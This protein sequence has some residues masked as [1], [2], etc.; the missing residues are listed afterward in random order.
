MVPKRE[1]KDTHHGA[2]FMPQWGCPYSMDS[3]KVVS[4]CGTCKLNQKHSHI[5][6]YGWDEMWCYVTGNIPFPGV[7]STIVDAM[8]Q[9][10]IVADKHFCDFIEDNIYKR[11]YVIGT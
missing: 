11:D 6:G 4:H 7:H 10:T 8:A 1:S 3:K 9:Y 2:L 5:I